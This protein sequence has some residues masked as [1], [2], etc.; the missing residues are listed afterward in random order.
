MAYDNTNK[1]AI[2]NR[3]AKSGL[4]YQSGRLNVDG[5]EFN[6][7]LFKNNKDGNEARPD[8]N[9]VVEP[10][11]GGNFSNNSSAPAT[12]NTPAPANDNISVEDI[13]F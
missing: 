7:S 5:K 12:N 4:Q 13:P 10:V 1:G 9:I 8:F 11:E 6:I 2:W 3:T